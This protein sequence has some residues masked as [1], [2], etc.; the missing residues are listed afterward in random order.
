VLNGFAPVASG[1]VG[2]GDPIGRGMLLD[3]MKN[4]LLRFHQFSKRIAES[5]QIEIRLASGEM[6]L[7]EHGTFGKLLGE[8]TQALNLILGFAC[9]S[10]PGQDTSTQAAV[11]DLNSGHRTD[12]VLG[13]IQQRNGFLKCFLD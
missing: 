8:R 10:Q 7:T 1:F 2:P 4:R 12:G 9:P 11:G 6:G 13:L 5:S 3:W